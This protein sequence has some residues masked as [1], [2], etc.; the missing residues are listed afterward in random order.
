MT[1][2]KRAACVLL[3][4]AAG[5]GIA[6]LQCGLTVRTY[7]VQ[8]EKLPAG[9]RLRVVMLSDLH[10]YIYGEDQMPLL[11][12]VADLQPDLIALCGDI[13]D[14]KRTQRGAWMLLRQIA[15]I[16]PCCYVS[17]NHEYWSA[18]P[19]DIFS[20]IENCGIRVLRDSAQ[21]LTVNGVRLTVTGLDDPARTG[22]RQPHSYGD[23]DVYRQTIETLSPPSSDDSLHILLAHRPEFMEDYARYPF[24]LVLCGHAHGGQ[25]RIPHLLN[26]LIAPNQGFFPKYAGGRYDFD[27]TTGIVG[28]G[29]LIDWK[30][31]VF[32][33]PEI[34]TV[35][36]VS[37]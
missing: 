7:T 13:V 16:A 37:H 18:D 9:K 27:Q 3:L 35:D 26:G 17:G 14:D 12:R 22:D 23:S 24:D 30:P 25:W 28:R 6:G 11:E 5:V 29:L 2:K 1:A 20:R 21:P 34:V 8:T 31:R 15:A 19:E 10:S 33:P 4:C 36:L 32:N